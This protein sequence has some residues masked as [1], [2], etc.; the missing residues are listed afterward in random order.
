MF[1]FSKEVRAHTIAHHLSWMRPISGWQ[2]T[3]PVKVILPRSTKVSGF[4]DAADPESRGHD[5]GPLEFLPVEETQAVT[6]IGPHFNHGDDSIEGQRRLLN[7]FLSD[8][9]LDS[10]DSWFYTPMALSFTAHLHPR[11]TV[12]TAWMNSPHS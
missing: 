6:V 1:R 3:F 10:F 12:T 2:S 8:R 5:G 11:V 7:R 4:H 9:C